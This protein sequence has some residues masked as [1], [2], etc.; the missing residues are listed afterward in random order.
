M[1]ENDDALDSVDAET[2]QELAKLVDEEE[3]SGELDEEALQRLQEREK[4]SHI[5]PQADPLASYGPEFDPT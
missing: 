5:V 2:E 1:T 4:K 3:A